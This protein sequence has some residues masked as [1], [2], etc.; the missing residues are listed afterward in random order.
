ME[1]GKKQKGINSK[2]SERLCK[3]AEIPSTRDCED[4]F[5]SFLSGTLFFKWRDRR[6]RGVS[7]ESCLLAFF[8]IPLSLAR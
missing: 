8:E 5:R 6:D 1:F 7:Q 2:G 3:K 4:L